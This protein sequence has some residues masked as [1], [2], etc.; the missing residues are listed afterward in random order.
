M[1]YPIRI[2]KAARRDLEE[3]YLWIAEH[4]SPEKAGYVLDRLSEVSES[5]AAYP[6]RGSRPKELPARIRA[7]YRQVFF[8]P[9]R[10]IYEISGKRVVIHLIA[11]GRRNMRAL[12][13]RRL[14]GG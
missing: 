7:D 14:T 9:Y 1:I 12:L 4:D 2:T 3:I 8:K 10:L 11:D 5:V 6:H 13:M